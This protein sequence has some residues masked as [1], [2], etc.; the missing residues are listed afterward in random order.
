MKRPDNV[1]YTNQFYRPRRV[2]NNGLYVLFAVTSLLVVVTII[3]AVAAVKKS[4]KKT[5]NTLV[6]PTN[7][8]APVVTDDSGNTID[9]SGIV[10]NTPEPTPPPSIEA[11]QNPVLYPA[12]AGMDVPIGT[13]ED[14][15]SPAGRNTTEVVYNGNEKVTGY[16]RADEIHFKDPLFYQQVGGILTFRGNNFRNCATWGTFALDPAKSQHLE[17]IWSYNGLESRWSP[18]GFWWSGTG[19]TGQPLAVKWDWEVQQIM[20]IRAEKKSKQGLTEIIVAAED[21]YVYFFDIDDGQKTRDP[22]KIGATIK[23]TPAV[24]PRGY[25]ILYVG[26]GD[27]NG[28][29]G[30]SKNGVIG[31]RIFSLIDFSLLHFQSGIDSRAYRTSWGGCDSSPIINGET[32]T[33]IYP[34]ENGIIYTVKLNTQFNAGTGALSIN[35]QFVDYKY[36][37]EDGTSTTHGIE[38]SMAIYDHYGWATDNDGNLICIDLNTMS[39]VWSRRL[40][41]DSDV[42]PV[43]EEENGHV[44]LYTGTE[45]DWQRNESVYQGAAYT[46]KFD[47]MT[48]EQVWQT[49]QNCYTSN[50]DTSA[51]DVNGGLLATPALGKGNA[52][53]L[54]FFSY[55]MTKG[56]YRGN[57][58]VAYDKN[59]G[60]QVWS[61]VMEF[62]EDPANVTDPYSWSSPVDIYDENGNAY[63]I[64][65]DSYGQIHMLDALTGTHISHLRLIADENQKI[66]NI[67][68]SPIVVDGILVIGSRGNFMYGVKIS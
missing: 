68:S 32:D 20:N 25:P 63:I 1:R 50:G 39:L 23:G 46:Y 61:Y 5:D 10:I 53:N 45:V 37:F 28:G 44:Y 36:T 16:Q 59:T 38:S 55:C 26:Q 40:E 27:D 22:L 65:Y 51:G 64:I 57:T 62:Y 15:Y 13:P 58:I 43:L 48:G 35:P 21:G 67:E 31:W 30:A 7:D 33:L 8:S 12:T 2:N 42:T 3:L 49:S 56:A 60:N 54:V 41:D 29:E 34:S 17:Q 66:N 11:Y 18:L 14:K 24:D 19:W 4:K 47:A 52:S 9:P 6:V